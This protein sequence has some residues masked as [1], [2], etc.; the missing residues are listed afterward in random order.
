GPRDLPP[1][2]S[3]PIPAPSSHAED[4]GDVPL[5]DVERRHILGVLRRYGRNKVRTAKVLGINVQ[6][7][8][9]KLKAYEEESRPPAEQGRSP[10]G[11]RSVPRAAPSRRAPSAGRRATRRRPCGPSRPPARRARPPSAPT[12]RRRPRAHGRPSSGRRSRASPPAA[13]RGARR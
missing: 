7:L 4:D 6:T 9:H 12:S 5:A 10:G 1:S 2:L 11:G 13:R 3:E 8:Y